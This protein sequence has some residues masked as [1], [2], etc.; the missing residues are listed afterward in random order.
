MSEHIRVEVPVDV[1]PAE[2]LQTPPLETVHAA[3][4]LTAPTDEQIQAIDRVFINRDEAT[5]AGLLT[6][7]AS[8]PF[9]IE[10][11]R[12]HLPEKEPEER[13]PRS[14]PESR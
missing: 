12:E 10:L 6:L 9:L 14:E 3:A 11:A 8:T 5:V 13:K 1:K 4:S 2:V 7:W